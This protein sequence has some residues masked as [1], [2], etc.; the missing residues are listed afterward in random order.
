MRMLTREELLKL[1]RELEHRIV[2]PE[3]LD[4]LDALFELANA[5]LESQA[6]THHHIKKGTEYVLI[7]YG[8]MQAKN[9]GDLLRASETSR[10]VPTVDMRE[11]AIYRSVEDG[12]LWARPREE[13][14]DGRFVKIQE[15]TK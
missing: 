6:P 7:G 14:E 1:R 5:A 9:W 13:F 4:V 12:S 15:P 10:Y 11:V 3:R 2:Q 8:R